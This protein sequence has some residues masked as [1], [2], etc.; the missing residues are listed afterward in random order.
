MCSSGD[1]ILALIQI[2]LQ[3]LAYALTIEG[4]EYI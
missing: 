1:N 2:I 4:S 3:L